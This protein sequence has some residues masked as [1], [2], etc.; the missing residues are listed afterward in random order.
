MCALCSASEVTTLWR[1]A[2]I[3]IIII[4]IT[5]VVVIIISTDFNR[6]KDVNKQTMSLCSVHY[7]KSS[8]RFCC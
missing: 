5:V 1:Y 8:L 2:N 7:A 3:I 6:H 4:I